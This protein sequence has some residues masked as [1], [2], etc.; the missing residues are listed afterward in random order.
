MN[1]LTTLFMYFSNILAIFSQ[2]IAYISV[3]CNL[4]VNCLYLMF[5]YFAKHDG[6]MAS[7]AVD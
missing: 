1:N 5:S 6:L 2:L 3:N 4:S 7:K